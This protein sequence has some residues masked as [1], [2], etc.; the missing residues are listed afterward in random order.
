[1]RK[2]LYFNQQKIV[3]SVFRA[4]YLFIRISEDR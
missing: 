1:M 2:Y 4:Y 3:V